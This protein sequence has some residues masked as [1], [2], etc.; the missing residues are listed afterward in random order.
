VRESTGRY[1]EICEGQQKVGKKFE[2]VSRNWGKSV[3]GAAGS[4][5]R[6]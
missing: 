1:A 4:V 6:V 5:A 3:R 2:G